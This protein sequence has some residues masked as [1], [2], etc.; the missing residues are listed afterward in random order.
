VRAED[1]LEQVLK[2][3]KAN[4][5]VIS[6]DINFEIKSSTLALLYGEVLFKAGVSRTHKGNL[7]GFR[8]TKIPIS[9]H[10]RHKF[11]S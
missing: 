8:T 9:I 3:L 6:Y 10:E 7:Q 5:L 11:W 2:V 1:Y 4:P